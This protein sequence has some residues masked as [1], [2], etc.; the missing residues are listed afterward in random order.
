MYTVKLTKH[1]K[2][3]VE[4]EQNP[5]ENKIK[6]KKSVFTLKSFKVAGKGGMNIYKMKNS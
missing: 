5:E 4:V 2:K 1:N 3:E 6:T